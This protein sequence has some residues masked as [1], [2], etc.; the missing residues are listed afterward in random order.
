V[1]GGCDARPCRLSGKGRAVCRVAE[2]VRCVRLSLHLKSQRPRDV[3]N[4]MC[5]C[6]AE[7]A[8]IGTV[9]NKQ[10]KSSLKTSR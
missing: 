7:K 6:V 2:K 9:V 3:C 4:K 5:F 8:D 10:V 1:R